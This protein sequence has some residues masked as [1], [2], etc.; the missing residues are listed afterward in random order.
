M[1]YIARLLT[2]LLPTLIGLQA[3]TQMTAR[4][5]GY[6]PA[7]GQPWGRWRGWGLYRPWDIARWVWAF[8]QGRPNA[9][10]LPLLVVW[11][12]VALG[13]GLMLLLAL[14]HKREMVTTYGSARWANNQ[15]VTRSGLL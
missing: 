4:A 7:L 11:V 15:D 14:R 1:T 2:M 8:G 6:H 3:A 10:R 13:I 5:F 12:A 9:F